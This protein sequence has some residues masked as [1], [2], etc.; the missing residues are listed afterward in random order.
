MMPCRLRA[1]VIGDGVARACSPAGNRR[2]CSGLVVGN[3]S[4]GFYVRVEDSIFAVVGPR[5]AHGPVHAVMDALPPAPPDQSFVRIESGRLLTDTC[6]VD[7]SRAVRYRPDPPSPTQ[8][9]ALAPLLAGLDRQDGV[10]ID[11]AEVWKPARAAVFRSDLHEART[12]LQGLGSGLTPTG[13]DVLAGILLFSHWADPLSDAAV[14]VASR[15]A[16]TDLS[17]CFLSWA[18]VGQSIQPVHDLVDTAS[19]SEM[20]TDSRGASAVRERFVQAAAAVASIGS[21]SGRGILA[22]LGLAATAWLNR[23]RASTAQGFSGPMEPSYREQPMSSVRRGWPDD[24]LRDGSNQGS[25]PPSST[26]SLTLAAME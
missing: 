7:L 25:V 16:T 13:D 5:I 8:L 21:S 24:G 17:R 19:G 11:L 23:Q 1:T 9:Q 26:A 12:L 3:F 4:S 18:A 14:E 10:P 6:T 20:L 15:V 2:C 22:G